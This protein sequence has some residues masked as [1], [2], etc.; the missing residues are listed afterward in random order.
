MFPV[1]GNAVTDPDLKATI[2]GNAQTTVDA[3]TYLGV[4][5]SSNAEWDTH[6]EGIFRCV[7]L[8]FF[9]KKLLRLTTPLSLF[10]NLSRRVYYH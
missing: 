2:N 1:K 6:A 3:V 5:F 7:R 8:S 9:V 10:A 4:T